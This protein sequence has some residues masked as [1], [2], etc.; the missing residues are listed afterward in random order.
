MTSPFDAIDAVLQ[1][2]VGAAFGEEL[3]VTPRT[4]SQYG[5]NQTDTERPIRNVLGVFSLAPAAEDI[6]GQRVGPQLAGTTQFAHSRAEAWISAAE[7]LTLGYAVRKGDSVT[8]TAASS[9]PVY[10]VTRADTSD[11]GDV[12]LILV[13]ENP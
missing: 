12:T 3:R 11:Q 8:I 9:Q 5:G 4:A 7:Y 10:T 1:G 6:S 2:A 13:A